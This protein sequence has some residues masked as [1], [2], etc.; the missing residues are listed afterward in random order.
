MAGHQPLVY[1][2][3]LFIY[4]FPMPAPIH[5]IVNPHSAGGYTGR[6]WP[7]IKQ[8]AEKLL[9]PIGFSLTERA[10]HAVELT[11]GALHAGA[12]LIVS[13]GGDGTNNEVVNG[14]F[15]DGKL[16]NP[17][18]QFGVVCSGTGSDFIKTAQ[19]P[20]A[21]A[22]ALQILAEAQ[23][24]PTDAGRMT[25]RDHQGRDVE[26][27]YINIA[28]FGIGGH[29]DNVVNNTTKALGG[30]VSFIL[31]SV[32]ATLSY[33]NQP[34]RLQVDDGPLLERTVFNVAVAN[35]RFFGAGMQTAPQAI[36]DDGLFDVV[37]V[38]DLTFLERLQFGGLI[39][40]GRHLGMAKVEF[41]RGKKVVAT[42]SERVLLDVDGEQ[43]GLLPA[44]FEV[45]P[46]KI[47]MRRP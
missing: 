8:S 44:S 16:V 43:P 6:V 36:L 22:E 7:E 39:Y 31:G 19:I 33:K 20:R 32:R 15:A 28:S 35:G 41:L 34:V 38:G 5:F 46:G 13:L 30:K 21:Y 42:S 9:G 17:Q 37:I 14:F 1:F 12:E 24:K 45:L 4:S 26:R 40:S 27:Y 10:W 18:A 29:A 2:F 11:R 3:W 23:A 47:L 25:L